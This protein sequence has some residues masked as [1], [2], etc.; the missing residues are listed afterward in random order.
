MR[1]GAAPTWG[2]FVCGIGFLVW[3]AALAWSC[4]REYRRNVTVRVTVGATRQ[5]ESGRR[6]WVELHEKEEALGGERSFFLRPAGF[7]KRE[8]RAGEQLAVSVDARRPVF[9]YPAGQY[10]R[11]RLWHVCLVAGALGATALIVTLARR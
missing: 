1:V 8:F 5:T 7:R 2:A 11:C 6:V 4:V 10:A 9:F 3:A